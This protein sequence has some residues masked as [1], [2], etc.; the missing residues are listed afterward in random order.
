M[1]QLTFHSSIAFKDHKPR[2]E[3]GGFIRKGKRKLARPFDAKRPVHLVLK[4]S[5]A[6]GSLSLQRPTN[7]KTL[8]KRVYGFAPKF[9]IKVLEFANSGNHLHLLI[10]AS[11]RKG[12]QNY[13]RTVTAV[14]AREVSGARKG[15]KFGKFWDAPAFSR[16]ISWGKALNLVKRYLALNNLEA[17]G[18]LPHRRPNGSA[19]SSTLAIDLE[20]YL[21]EKLRRHSRHLVT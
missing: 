18:F 3:H 21:E 6:K 5:R 19:K 9:G 15:R 17:F 2:Q 10:M 20:G 16:V 11:N 7:E 1:R 8:S 14:L 4:S 13:L 12:F